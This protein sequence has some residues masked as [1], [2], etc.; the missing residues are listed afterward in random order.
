MIKKQQNQFVTHKELGI[1]LV[2]QTK[3]IE[4]LLTDQTTTILNTV[5]EKIS[6]VETKITSFDYRITTIEK[7]IVDFESRI[8]TKIDK[9]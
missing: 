3:N 8:N 5:D 2:R 6:R 7:R 9:L 4:K 1:A